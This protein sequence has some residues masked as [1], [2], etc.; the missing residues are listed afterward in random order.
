MH[1]LALVAAVS[2]GFAAS[3]GEVTLA[4]VQ[5]SAARPGTVA[6]AELLKHM[7]LVCGVK[8]SGGG[9]FCIALGQRAP[10]AGEP[11]P[12]TSYG[13]RV[14]DTVYLWGDDSGER[15]PKC[16]DKG[17]PGT[18]FAVYGFIEDVL[19]VRWVAP[20]D[21]GIVFRPAKVVDVPDG[22]SWRYT[23]PLMMGEIRT[24]P[25]RALKYES[26]PGG[27]K[28]L[29]KAMYQTK[30]EVWRMGQDF[31]I[32]ALRMKLFVKGEDW[33]FGHAFMD[34]NERFLS[35]HPEYLALQPDGERGTKDR[36]WNTRFWM[37][38]CLS[39]DAV[40][41]QL[42]SDWT[43]KGRPRQLNICPND[44]LGL[45]CRCAACCALDCPL[46]PEEPFDAHKTDRYLNFAN[47]VAAKALALRPDVN[48]CTYAYQ[49]YRLPPRREK[50]A[51]P[52]NITI[53]LVPSYEDDN[54]A[55]VDGWKKAGLKRFTLRPNF[56]FYHGVLPRGFERDFFA[57]LRMFAAAGALGFDYDCN[58]RGGV[59]DF[60]KYAV[61]RALVDSNVTFE[62][63]E[64]DFLSQYGTAA[65]AMREYFGR[66]RARGEKALADVRRNRPDPS[67][68]GTDDSCRRITVFRA[69]PHAELAG[70]LAV[71]KR[72]AAV[73][74]LS[75]AE[76]ARVERRVLMCEH[77]MRTQDFIAARDTLPR[78][79]FVKKAFDLIDYRTSIWRRLP[80]SWGSI[81]RGYWDE[82][83]WWRHIAPEV[84]A[85][86]PEMELAD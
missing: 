57:N 10:G 8:P 41:D 22:W 33:R 85:K 40:I 66:V 16:E 84:K 24:P 30:E 51:Y 50:V 83:W 38:L 76:R 61:A 60:E 5:V 79:E 25:Y 54:A 69:N 39:N 7:E 65:D 77:M 6:E 62:T 58:V 74:G 26:E 29:P 42:L 15:R 73:E 86:F 59:T 36:K 27:N 68:A 12:F 63:V 21:E 46:S 71:L 3:A 20:G 47:R 67:E 56:L 35:T 52:D 53:G 44:G 43:A 75:S 28:Y 2:L 72:A 31:R 49:E 34:W 13:R 82:V 18:L 17:L 32:W 19:G 64:R 4:T 9:A 81:F 14:G 1:R 80:D 78:A 70:D 23:P 37:K 48:V 55:L 11:E 45:H